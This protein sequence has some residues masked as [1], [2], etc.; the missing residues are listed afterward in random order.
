MRH[1]GPHPAALEAKPGV[2]D[3]RDRKTTR[4]PTYSG[5]ITA[6]EDQEFTF[7]RWTDQEAVSGFAY[8]RIHPTTMFRPYPVSGIIRRPHNAHSLF[9]PHWTA[10]ATASPASAD[11]RVEFLAGPRLV[12][13]VS[14]V[15]AWYLSRSD[16]VVGLMRPTAPFPI[17]V[18]HNWDRHLGTGHR[19]LDGSDDRL[20]G[21][22]HNAGILIGVPLEIQPDQSFAAVPHTEHCWGGCQRYGSP[23]SPVAK[24]I[25]QSNPAATGSAKP[26]R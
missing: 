3:T 15:Q 19:S 18:K 22:D 25:D 24:L 5:S 9:G 13:Y 1:L 4:R 8:N 12:W 20:L 21:I 16:E 23:T 17:T 14:P 2:S 26:V 10:R 7:W 11:V 6:D